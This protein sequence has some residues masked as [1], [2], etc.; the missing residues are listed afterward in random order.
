[1]I[2]A[3]RTTIA[4]ARRLRSNTSLPEGLLWQH[5]R[6]RPFGLKF[7]RQHPM[8]GFATDFY[9]H[10]P[11]LVIEIDGIAHDMADRPIRDARRDLSLKQRGSLEIVRIAAS[12][13]LADVG[14][15]ADSIARYANSKI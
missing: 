15:V 4:A 6:A 9:C 2:G 12:D 14:G 10:S 1:M 5:L 11:R 3:D 7:R 8:R 13:V